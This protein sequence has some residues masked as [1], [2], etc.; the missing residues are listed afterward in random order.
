MPVSVER[1]LAMARRKN[2]IFTNKRHS[3]KAIMGMILGIISLASM[4]AVVFLSYSK[5]GQVPAG[6]GFTGLFATVF[7][8]IG[9]VLGIT[10]LR[11]KNHFLFFPLMGTI[12][13]GLALVL[14]GALIY[15]AV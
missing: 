10:T 14:I 2:F 6:Y 13:N 4:A 7:S 12:L 3:D 11:E 15:A 9:L 8:V 1:K 5:G